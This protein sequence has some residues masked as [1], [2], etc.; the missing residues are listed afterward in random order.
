MAHDASKVIMGAT[1]SSD[2][3]VSDYTGNPATYLAGLALRR[4]SDDTLSVTLADGQWLGV[5][6][7]ASLSDTSKTAVCRSGLRVPV[8]LEAKPAYGEVEITN[9][10]NLTDGTDD[11]VTVGAT[12]FTATDGAVTPTQATFD[13]RTSNVLAAASLAAQINAHATAGALVEAVAVGAVVQI[14]ARAN[15]V[16]GDDIAL[17][18][19]QLGAGVGATVSGANLEDG[20]DAPDYV[21]IGEKVYFSDTTGKADD[22]YSDATISDAVYV[23]G[24]LT[25]IAEDGSEV[26]AALVDM[27]GGL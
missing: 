15:T 12:A 10:S 19:E 5:S 20:G 21:V 24:V 17:S 2:K 11:T 13:A 25:G 1:Q 8:L 16:A 18:Y 23:S 14:R 22:K 7:G 9:Y 27:G 3:V 26:Y 6:L 4:K